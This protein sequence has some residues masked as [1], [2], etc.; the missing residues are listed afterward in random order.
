MLDRSKTGYEFPPFQV[1]VEKGRLRLF[2]KAIGETNPVYF[3]ETLA[4]EAGYRSILMP[5]TFPFCLGR[6]IPDP[7]DTLT[8]LNID[9]A[10][11]LHGAQKFQF[12]A[13]ICAGDIL[14]GQK[15]IMDIYDKKNGALEFVEVKTDFRD[16]EGQLLCEAV[17]TIIVKRK[18]PP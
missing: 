6:E 1:E 15:R 3:D 2:A 18:S 16:R 11:V 10:S 9:L 17:Q 4:R 8:L 5:P 7:T 14:Y 12:H 13:G